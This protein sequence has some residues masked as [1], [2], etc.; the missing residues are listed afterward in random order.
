[1]RGFTADGLRRDGLLFC[2]LSGKGRV[3]PKAKLR[4]FQYWEIPL[5]AL[6]G[7]IRDIEEG[8]MVMYHF[9]C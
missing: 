3:I 9:P 6:D 4:D 7:L 5:E 8:G 1:L 2:W